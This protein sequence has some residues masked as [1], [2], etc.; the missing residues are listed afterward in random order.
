VANKKET[1]FKLPTGQ[2]AAFKQK[3]ANKI[4]S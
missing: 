2:I 1:T 3:I 4:N